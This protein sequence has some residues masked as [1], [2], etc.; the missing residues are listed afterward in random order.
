MRPLIYTR[1]G[2][3]AAIDR[4]RLRRDAQFVGLAMI[5]TVAASQVVALIP[6]LALAAG[7]AIDLSAANYGLSANG[8]TLLNMLLY[9]LTIGPP[10]VAASLIF[11]QRIHPFAAHRRVDPVSFI[12]LVAVGAAV[13][14]L[15]N[16]VAGF[17]ANFFS[18]FGIGWPDA[19]DG[20]DTAPAS[21]ALNLLSTALLPGILEEMVFR[22][23]LLTAL[24]RYGDRYAILVTSLL[25]ALLH[26][27]VLQ[28]PFAF[29]VGLICG[30][31]VVVTG[32]IWT[33]VAL[34]AFNNGVAVIM[35]YVEQFLSE[36]DASRL[37]MTSFLVEAAIGGVALL[38]LALTGSRY[39]RRP[40]GGWTGLSGKEK[41]GAAFSAPLFSVAL[42]LLVLETLYVT[43]SYSGM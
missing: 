31:L 16:F 25:F 23:Y 43:V 22:G 11:R 2:L 13:C 5:L 7:G 19:T 40:N 6:L 38:V 24:R 20:I 37:E 28:I 9:I 18:S 21:L 8:Y 4:H 26:A 39:L 32:N 14:V 3:A 12:S 36:T 10:A 34:H 15:A 41:W 30:Y 27:N 35:T 29:I 17:I 33:A 42:A 1:Q